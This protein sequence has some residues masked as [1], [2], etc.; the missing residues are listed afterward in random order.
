MRDA[1]VGRIA[2]NEWKP[3]FSIPSETNLAREMGVSPGTMRKAL[4]VLAKEHV[5]TRRQGRG[6]FVNN[7]S[8]KEFFLRYENVRG[9]DGERLTGEVKSFKMTQ[10]AAN[11]MECERLSLQKGDKVYRIQRVRLTVGKPL[12]LEE[13]SLP[14]TL[15][16][17][18]EERASIPDSVVN[19]A[20]TYGILLGTAT[21]RIFVASA[22]H[23]V[24][25]ALKVAP[26]SPVA[27][28]DRVVRA[29]DTRPVEWRMGWCNLAENYYLASMD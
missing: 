4:D 13:A 8:S 29:V 17:R 18:L 9:P 11:E 14:E 2:N 12:M 19:L 26:G 10:S 23:K 20:Q 5:I 25:E 27:V 24:A 3:D 21:E 16:P 22:S 28:L 1:L 6:T 7:Q 15:L